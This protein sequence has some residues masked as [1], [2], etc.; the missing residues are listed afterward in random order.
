MEKINRTP[1]PDWLQEKYEEWGR[2]WEI[3]YN[4]TRNSR[5]I[6]YKNNKKGHQDLV[7]ELSRMTKDHCSFCDAYPMGAR[8]QPTIEHFKPK[9]KFPLLAYKWD[10]L[11]LCCRI[12]Q[13]KGERFDDKLLKPDED[14][15]EFD[16]YFDIDWETGKLLPNE[17]ATDEDKAR[18]EI[19]IKLYKLNVNGKPEDRLE[20]LKKY[21]QLTEPEIDTFSYRF[22]ITRGLYPAHEQSP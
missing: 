3:K 12:C 5:F 2:D 13:G 16:D 11:F 8:I 21:E 17:D 19:T 14:T 15:Y 22:F 4:T 18:A 7:E 6:W 20:E 10:N 1:A 9:T